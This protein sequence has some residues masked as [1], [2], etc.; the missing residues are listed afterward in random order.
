MSDPT[1]L[2]ASGMREGVLTSAVT[3]SA[4]ATDSIQSMG[5]AG[6]RLFVAVGDGYTGYY[7][8]EES[9]RMKLFAEVVVAVIAPEA[10]AVLQTLDPTS[11]NAKTVNIED[12]RSIAEA[13]QGCD[14]AY[15][16]P[17][18]RHDKIELTRHMLS[19]VRDAGITKCVVLSSIG[20]DAEDKPS[21]AKFL[22]IERALKEAAFPVSCILRAGFYSQNMLLYAD[23]LNE[24]YLALPIGAGKM[25]PVDIQDLS[26]AAMKVC[27]N[28]EAHN[29]Q[30]YSLIGN[31]LVDGSRIARA[32][33]VL[34][35]KEVE[36]RPINEREAEMIVANKKGLDDSEANYLLEFYELVRSGKQEM[37]SDDVQRLLEQIP[38]SVEGFLKKHEIDLTQPARAEL[39]ASGA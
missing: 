5:I 38:T 25:A 17:P 1:A 2:S 11:V 24:G 6:K 30:V 12:P 34:L 29:H 28:I 3:A 13:A 23:Q 16:V 20:A 31:E 27:A 4:P 14:V 15:L 26:G 8:V 35:G 10:V 39:K 9:V 19:G 7:A 33:S 21:L 18:A 37:V 36:Y 32:A 22:E